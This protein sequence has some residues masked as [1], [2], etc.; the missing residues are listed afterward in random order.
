M[1][2]TQ[3]NGGSSP[4]G[5]GGRG[6]HVMML[7]QIREILVQLLDALLVRLGA[8]SLQPLVQLPNPGIPPVISQLSSLSFS[9]SLYILTLEKKIK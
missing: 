5:E 4:K 6:S 9:L 8:F 7:A 3:H 1:W 2:Q